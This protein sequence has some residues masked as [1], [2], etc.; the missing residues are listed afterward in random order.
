MLW[1]HYIIWFNPH[2]VKEVLLRILY[3][4]SARKLRDRQVRSLV[5]VHTAMSGIAGIWTQ[6]WMAPNLSSKD[7]HAAFWAS[8]RRLSNHCVRRIIYVKRL[9]RLIQSWERLMKNVRGLWRAWGSL[10]NLDLF[11]ESVEIDTVVMSFWISF[12]IVRNLGFTVR[13]LRSTSVYQPKIKDAY[14]Y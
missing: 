7:F 4:P 6:M 5:Q 9:I 2:P 3:S 1:V 8:Y 13:I 12:L 11:T 10:L 14:E